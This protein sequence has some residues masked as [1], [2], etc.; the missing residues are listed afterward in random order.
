MDIFKHCPGKK[1]ATGREWGTAGRHAAA[2]GAHRR[3]VR[4]VAVVLAHIMVV[5]HADDG[6][7]AEKC[8]ILGDVQLP[9]EMGREALR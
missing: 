7:T 8:A 9:L 2:R 4:P 1:R 3:I 5:V 6:H